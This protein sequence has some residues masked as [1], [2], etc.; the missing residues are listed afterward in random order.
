MTQPEDLQEQYV[1]RQIRAAQAGEYP[2]HK[3]IDEAE[4]GSMV[5]DMEDLIQLGEDMEAM[6]TN[7]EDKKDGLLPDPGQ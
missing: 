3:D 7:R 5:N 2:E 4:N 1:T 6:Q